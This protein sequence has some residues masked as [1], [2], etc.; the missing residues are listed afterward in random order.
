M[1]SVADLFF[2]PKCASCGEL[3]PFKGLF[4]SDPALESA[5]CPNC[6]PLWEREK[7]EKCGVCEQEVSNCRCVTKIMQS[8]GCKA[9]CKL[10]FYRPGNREEVGN[11]IVYRIKDHA[12]RNAVNFL[13]EELLPAVQD[14]MDRA[15]WKEKS[16][17]LTYL[18]RRSDVVL[19]GG[20]D[21]AK[22]LAAA[23]AGRLELPLIPLIGRHRK[24]RAPQKFLTPAKRLSNAKGA[25]YLREKVQSAAAGK[26]AILVDD[27]VTSGASM[28]VGVRL[29]RRA[30]AKDF[31]TVAVASDECNRN[32]AVATPETGSELY[33][34]PR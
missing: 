24:S 5:L 23:L 15:E 32:P 25:F 29:L 18:P 27:I 2:P 11:R 16:F 30:G 10:V 3:L 31:L 4:G 6:L 17:F 19:K 9:F 26:I 14:C 13:A 22:A 20:N 33:R 8:A 1:K 12:D 21:Q 28:A 34:L 7:K